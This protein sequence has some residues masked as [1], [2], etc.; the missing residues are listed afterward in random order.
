MNRKINK[1]EKGITLIALIITIVILIIL[2]TITINFAFGE[3]G[4]IQRAEDAKN[5]TEESTNEEQ[6][7]LDSAL[8][9]INSIL[10]GN[11]E[12]NENDSDELMT[13]EEAKNNNS[14]NFTSTT[15]IKDDLENR[16][17]VPGGFHIASDSGLKVEE[18]I[19]IEDSIGNQFVWIPV[20]EYNVSTTINSTGKLTN[21]LSRRK[22]SSSGATEIEGDTG[23]VEEKENNESFAFY[24]EG[25]TH[26]VDGNSITT[27]AKDQ[28]GEFISKTE[29]KGGFYIGR[30]EAG[31]EIKRTSLSDSQTTPLVQADKFP[32]GFVTRDTAKAQAESMYEDNSNVTS[33][34]VSSYAWD[35]TLNFICQTNVGE[36]EKYNIALTTDPAYGNIYTGGVLKTGQ[37]KVDGEVS[38]KYS[39]IFDMVGNCWEWTTEYSIYKNNGVDMNSPCVFRGGFCMAPIYS[40]ISNEV[41]QINCEGFECGSFRVQLYVNN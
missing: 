3:D 34:L 37:Y 35:T 14:S 12:N 13:V 31:T 15:T 26:D 29:E 23:V 25:A 4:L 9:K 36:N 1:L 41:M 17:T 39:N 20:G 28:I 32:Y 27:V 24:G 5:L 6:E 21:N 2:A 18:G 38:D 22:M 7:Q 11:G 8:S 19:V 10:A 30:Y 16:I 40:A 33:E